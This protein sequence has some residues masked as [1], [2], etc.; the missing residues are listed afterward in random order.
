M[1]KVSL[2]PGWDLAE[3]VV[4]L[5]SMKTMRHIGGPTVRL[6]LGAWVLA[7]LLGLAACS[8]EPSTVA[9][10]T[11]R[12]ALRFEPPTLD[13]SLATDGVS[14][15]VLTNI[16]EGLTQYNQQLEPVPAIARH[17]EFSEGGRVITYTLR[18][19]IGRASCRERV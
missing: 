9:D 19:E 2:R 14:F 17:W 4:S 16:M 13:W 5:I 8:G 7:G 3:A 11:L 6:G 1:A 15:N 18:E 10:R 12:M